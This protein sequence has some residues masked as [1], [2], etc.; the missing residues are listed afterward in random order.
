MG[1]VTR[2]LREHGLKSSPAGGGTLD[3]TRVRD[4]LRADGVVPEA[5]PFT[6]RP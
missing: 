1:T 6:R 2:G 3:G 5:G 4:W